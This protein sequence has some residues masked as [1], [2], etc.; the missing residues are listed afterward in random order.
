MYVLRAFECQILWTEE[1]QFQPTADLK[2]SFLP[3]KFGSKLVQ[4][5]KRKSATGFQIV[6]LA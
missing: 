5:Q 2:L 3:G 1:I 4:L 6:N